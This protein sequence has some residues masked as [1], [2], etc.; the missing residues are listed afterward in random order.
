MHIGVLGGGGAERVFAIL[1]NQFALEGHDIILLLNE[2]VVHEYPVDCRVRKV[3]LSKKIKRGV[4]KENYYRIKTIREIA[5]KENVDVMLAFMPESNIRVILASIGL[6]RIVIVS[7]RANPN[8]IYKKGINKFIVNIILSMASGI[9][10]QTEEIREWY[11]KQIQNKII[12]LP[13]PVSEEF[14]KKTWIPHSCSKNIVAVGRLSESKNFGLLIKAMS[15]VI[16]E[17]PDCKLNIY[18]DGPLKSYLQSEIN[19]AKLGEQIILHGKSINIIDKLLESDLYVLSSISEGMPNSLIEALCVG[20]PCVATDCLGGGARAL[21]KTGENGYLVKNDDVDSLANGII[22]LLQDRD[23]RLKYAKA[24]KK[25]ACL[26]SEE[27]IA[28]LWISF[29]KKCGSC[30]NE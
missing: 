25:N 24:A 20:M 2:E 18:G 15:T 23:M 19:K 21:I 12:V 27:E 29:I 10:V 26:Y 1:A 5:K 16:E 6:K 14:I 7:E 17:L 28:K 8:K 11:S 3:Y 9:V 4:L 30:N 22:C 13:N